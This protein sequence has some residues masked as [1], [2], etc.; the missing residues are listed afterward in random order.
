MGFFDFLRIGGSSKTT[1]R[2]TNKKKRSGF[3]KTIVKGASRSGKKMTRAERSVINKEQYRKQRELEAT[4]AATKR[5]STSRRAFFKTQA[6]HRAY[7]K[8]DNW[9][10]KRDDVR[11]RSQGRCQRCGKKGSSVHHLRY[12]EPGAEDRA[13]LAF[14]CAS[15]HRRI[16]GTHR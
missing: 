5:G 2:S 10:Q 12:T 4:A 9:K 11:D 8:S 7:I 13:H 3:H 14:V 15:C 1:S 16:H 6:E